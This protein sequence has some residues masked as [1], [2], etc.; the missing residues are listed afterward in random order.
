MTDFLSVIVSNLNPKTINCVFKQRAI[1]GGEA[2]QIRKEMQQIQKI[3]KGYEEMKVATY[4]LRVDTDYDKEWQWSYRADKVLALID[5]HDWDIL[6][7][8]EV[9]PTQVA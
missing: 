5:Y 1:G 3:V 8:Q 6:C 4:N 9:R 2:K 7:V